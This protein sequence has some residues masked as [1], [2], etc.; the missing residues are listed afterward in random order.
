M[1]DFE[2][3]QDQE[4]LQKKVRDFGA[5]KI[6]PHI[7]G[8]ESSHRIPPEMI[9]GLADLG[10]LGINFSKKFD[11]KD[12]DP[13]TVGIIC[14]ELA[15]ADIGCS[16][17]TFYLVPAAWGHVLDKY[18]TE[19]AK[20]DILPEVVKGQ[21]FLGIAAT[22]EEGGSDLVNMKTVA[23][24]EMDR[25]IVNGEKMYISGVR[26]I[27]ERMPAG[28][29]FVTLVKTDPAKGAKG[30]S[31]LWIRVKDEKGL[32]KGIG[33]TIIEEWGRKGVSAGG[34]VL[35]DVPVGEEALI[36]KENN[37]FKTAME[38]F[39]YARALIAVVCCGAAMG[40]LEYVMD[41]LKERKVFGQAIG[42]YEGVQFKLAEH[43]AKLEAQRLLAYKALWMLGKERT[44][45]G[46][47]RFEVTRAC[48]MAKLWAPMVAFEAIN[49]AIQWQGAFGY[50]TR[51]PL[52]LALKGVRSYYWAEGAAEIIRMIVARELL[53]KEYV[54][55]R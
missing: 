49:D 25:F 1:M 23:R 42:K 50:T 18:G 5:K 37:G 39:D 31:L 35:K 29:G 51:T 41:R 10:I 19:E 9:A 15:R 2:F 45:G 13:I 26:E 16:V 33:P 34:F 54:A 20:R 48:A 8:F 52:E 27:T 4:R 30:M 47:S 53:G 6:R 3:T 43:W 12:A 36:G 40:S 24:K 46:K 21:A 44:D 7:R 55:N 38:G 11:G 17:P 22:E 14:E 32:R 28:G